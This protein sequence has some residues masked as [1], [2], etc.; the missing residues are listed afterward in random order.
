MSGDVLT[1]SDGVI[2]TISSIL[3]PALRL[4]L[5]GMTVWYSSGASA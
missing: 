3:Y 4:G 2:D 1:A 5:A